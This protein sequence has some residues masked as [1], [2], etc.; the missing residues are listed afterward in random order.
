MKRVTVI[1][2]PAAGSLRNDVVAMARLVGTLKA[3]GLEVQNARTTR[4]GDATQMAIKAVAEN[5]DTVLV[6]G[7]D[8]TINEAAQSLIGTET[9]LAVWPLG[10]GNVLAKDLGLPSNPTAVAD[11]IARGLTRTISVGRASTPSRDWQRHFLLMAGIGVDATIVKAVDPDLKRIAG[12]GAYWVAGFDFLARF[13]LTRFRVTAG[14]QEHQATF[15]TIANS[16]SYGGWF[17]LAPKAEIDKNKLDLCLFD[18][19]SRLDSVRYALMSLNGS[20]LRSPRVVYQEVEMVM[21]NS[22]EE[23]LV[24]LDGDLVGT[25][26]MRF[27]IIPEALRVVAPPRLSER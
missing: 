5:S 13:P 18:V 16:A 22:N 8:G 15:A 7:G 25:L 12:I 11:L 24:Q 19:R 6:C 26:P 1:Y 20:H 3:H 9:A 2:N 17:S 27:E 10:T 14:G 4:A 23:A 21:A